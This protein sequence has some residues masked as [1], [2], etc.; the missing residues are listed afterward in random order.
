MVALEWRSLAPVPEPAQ[1]ERRPRLLTGRIGLRPGDRFAA[2]TDWAEILAGWQLV[3]DRG[4]VQYW[5]C[6]FSDKRSGW[7]ASTNH[8]GTDALHVFCNAEGTP[9]AAGQ[10]YSKFRAFS[11]L[12]HDGD[13]HAAA[14]ELAR[15]YRVNNRLDMV[16]TKRA[17]INFGAMVRPATRFI[18]S[19]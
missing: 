16:D 7:C 4:G 14:V 18:G 1:P 17:A 11:L 12:E 3:A 6:P 8:A 15:R 10:N 2:E 19:Y 13:D 5:R 9:F